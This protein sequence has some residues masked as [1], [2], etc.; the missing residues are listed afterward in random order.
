MNNSTDSSATT[1]SRIANHKSRMDW[2]RDPLHREDLDHVAYLDVVEPLE[3]D[4]AFEPGLHLADIILEPAQRGD[5]PLEHHHVVAEQSRLCF[6]RARDAPVGDHAA[7][8]GA[9]LRH[10][11]DL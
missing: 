1:K 3:A 8:D 4:A 6:A 5:L 9:H 11:E 2:R 7:G 10:L